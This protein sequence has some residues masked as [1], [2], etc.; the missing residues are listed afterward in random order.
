[1]VR[2]LQAY[3]VSQP[4]WQRIILLIVIGY[5]AAGALTGSILLIA[6]PDGRLMDMPVDIMHGA[7]RDFHIPGMI[8]FGLGILNASAFVSVLRR[9]NKDWF[10]AGMALAGLS[11]WFVVEI[12]ILQE[13][14]WLHAMWGIP[15]LIG[16]VVA[17]PLIA[18]RNATAKLQKGLLICGILASLWYI[19]INIYVPTQYDGYSPVSYTVSELSAINAPT[20]ILWVLLALPYPLLLS[21]FGWGVLQSAERNRSLRLVGSLILAY[22]VF[23]FYWPPMHMRGNEPTLTDTLHIVW[24]LV[25]IV[26]MWL[27][28][29]LGARALGKRFRLYTIISIG[30]HIVFGALTFLEAPNIPINGPTPTIGIWERVNIGIFMIWVAVIAFVL[31]RR[32]RSLV[33][34]G[35][36]QEEALSTSG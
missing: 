32:A 18:L 16:W 27:F 25:T 34:R 36:M 28:M 14:H 17:I 19:A 15:V 10:L 9:A 5:E 31:L 6:S 22:C 8:L 33:S 3:I 12:V 26:F 7:F 1:M 11:I 30:L 21:A 20:R 23:N 4:A 13:L 2:K 24:A 29:G 35:V